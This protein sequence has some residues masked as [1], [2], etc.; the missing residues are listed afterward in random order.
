MRHNILL[1]LSL[2][3]CFMVTLNFF[4]VAPVGAYSYYNWI[5]NSDFESAVQIME[6]GDAECGAFEQGLTYG[7]FSVGM[8][9]PSVSN[10][11]PQSGVW[12]YRVGV[13]DSIMWNFTYPEEILGA[14]IT[15][16]SGQFAD[17]GG[18]SLNFKVTYYYSDGTSDV[19]SVY[20]SAG[21]GYRYVSILND[22][23]NF[24]SIKYVVAIAFNQTGARGFDMDN[25]AFRCG[26]V[27]N[28]G[29]IDFYSYPWFCGGV[30]DQNHI[31]LDIDVGH[32][33]LQSVYMG[34]SESTAELVQFIPYADTNYIHYLELWYYTNVAGNLRVQFVYSDG[35]HSQQQHPTSV[36]GAWTHLIYSSWIEPDK[37]LMEIQIGLVNN[38][39][40]YINIDDVYLWSQVQCSE[41]NQRFHYTISPTPIYVQGQQCQCWSDID[42]VFYGYVRNSTGGH[43]EN[44]T[45]Q[46]T[47]SQGSSAGYVVNGAFNFSIPSRVSLNSVYETFGM[48]I[49]V[50]QG[51]EAWNVV[52]EWIVNSVPI[53][54]VDGDDGGSSGNWYAMPSYIQF[55]IMFTVVGLPA[56]VLGSA[57]AKAR[58][59]LQGLL[60]GAFLGLGCGVCVG[61]VPFWFVFLMSLFLILFLYSLARRSE[62]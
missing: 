8:G 6:H 37:Y 44:G 54:P 42:Y 9:A 14:D 32:S 26:G 30:L 1:S 23:M 17:L 28:Q 11:N 13:A 16:F 51:V 5:L 61:I 35:T 36:I 10:V 49:Q 62:G 25:L 2:F 31:G 22:V 41:E 58:W 59:G 60:L 46:V 3:F 50:G 7:N 56:V 39:L 19:S 43:D 57:G 15:G 48:L 40:G 38:Q 4:S 12:H 47:H 29:E 20:N 55:I 21:A 34:F 53:R 18:S 27:Q 24:S 33:G 45:F 52:I